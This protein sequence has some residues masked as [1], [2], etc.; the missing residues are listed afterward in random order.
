MSLRELT[1]SWAALLLVAILIYLPHLLHGGL[2]SDDWADASGALHPPGGPGLVNGVEHFAQKISLARPMVVL[3][4]PLKYIAL[5]TH[6][7]LLLALSIGLA[8]LV[9]M[10]AYAILR[11]LGMPW[12]HSLLVSALTLAYP[13]FDSTRVWETASLQSLALVFAF[14]GFWLAL[15]GLS[16]RSLRLHTGAVLLYLLSVL[17]YEV[18][19]PLIAAAGIIYVARDGWR[20]GRWRWGADLAV[21]AAGALWNVA[22]TPKSVSTLSGD[23]SHLREI[24]T[25]GGE[26]LART[27]YPL[28]VQ[29]HTST[30][31][32]FL[33]AIFAV[34]TAVHL[35]TP[36]KR[37]A[38]SGWGLSSWL[39][40]GAAGLLTAALGWA[41]FIP[42]DPYYTPSIFGVTNRVNGL[43]GF[44][45]ILL[46]YAAVGIV[47]SLCG[48]VA[49]RRLAIGAAVTLV[50]A[51][52]LGSAYVHVLERHIR[53]W[54]DAYAMEQDGLNRVREAFP[55]LPHGTTVFTSN[56]PANVTLGVP[57][58]ATTWDLNG[59]VQVTYADNTV[60]AYP[61]T[62]EL[63][64]QCRP[65]GIVAKAGEELEHV[66]PY[67]RA[68]LLDL[69][70][71]RH[72]TP[73]TQ[74]QC[75]AAKPRFGPGP[76]YLATAY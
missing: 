59:M 12:Y 76:L 73:R 62:E 46:T 65:H 40:L 22:H 1:L 6:I 36:S 54:R 28:G 70:T 52:A 19:I 25:Q 30:V 10:L 75:V 41:M 38:A 31:L 49:G 35:L 68:R 18:T 33:A 44:G 23:L 7:K 69:S 26:L 48:R 15:I 11:V 14:A 27:L 67:G 24:V 20:V 45:L 2:Y 72:L 32:V 63:E 39:L 47:G 56:Y 42:A 51:V 61:I 21:V 50:L 34:G 64:I 3:L 60:R 53:L 55:R 74:R 13:W 16:R 5:G 43:A 58:F 9:A 4:V 66:A 57:V 8:V 29:P 17:T 37:P 71:G